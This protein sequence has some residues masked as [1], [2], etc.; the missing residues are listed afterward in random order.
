MTKLF[1]FI[2]AIFAVT[3]ANISIFPL[4][5]L[6]IPTDFI[7]Q[8]TRIL[9]PLS[10][11]GLWGFNLQEQHHFLPLLSTILNSEEWPYVHLALSLSQQKITSQ[12]SVIKRH[13]PRLKL[14]LIH[15]AHSQE[16]IYCIILGGS[17]MMEKLLPLSGSYFED[18]S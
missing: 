4:L 2:T 15:T 11:I 7:A 16:T 9:F 5:V 14:P 10:S 6:I 17:S 3:M 13:I 12:V 18:S 1:P 8:T